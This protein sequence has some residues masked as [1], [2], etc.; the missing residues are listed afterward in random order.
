MVSLTRDEVKI[1][2]DD[3]KVILADAIA[4]Y[5]ARTGKTLQPA[6]IERSIIQ[7]YAYREL[8][9]RKG[10]N[11]AFVQQ[12]P[13][14]ATGIALDLCGEPMNC[15]RLENQAARCMLRFSV[16]GSHSTITIPMGTIVS[17][18]ETLLFTTL[19]EVQIRSTEQFVDVEAVANIT[20]EIGNGWEIGLIK[21]LKTVLSQENISVSNITETSGGI[22]TENDDDYRKRI[23]L[24][25]EAF[26]TCGTLGAYEYHTRSVS[27]YI[28][29]VAISTPQGG[30][31]Q[32]AVLTK[33]GVPNT[34]LLKQIQDYV[35]SEKRRTL[36]DTVNVIPAVEVRYSINATLDLLVD[37]DERAVLAEAEQTVQRYLS[38]RTQKMGVDIVPLDIAAALKV[39][40]VYNVTLTQP[41]LTEVQS[42]QWA[43]CNSISLKANA[44]RKNG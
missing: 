15:Y 41:T 20:G 28:A 44:E 34:A 37:M 38:E 18:T 39:S 12:F 22:E 29:D 40:G 33:N 32:I 9:V 24:A 8:L 14:F 13:Q 1:V 2:D 43:N 5:E 6:H 16:E 11:E 27:Q 23:L 10:V 36:C 42:G 31:V 25:P 4:D 21:T 7:T 26:T 17:A 35:A 3:V 19:I 30:M